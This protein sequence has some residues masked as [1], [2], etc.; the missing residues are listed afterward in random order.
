MES[1]KTPSHLT[2]SDIKRSKSKSLRSQSLI[3]CKGGGLGHMLLLNINKKAYM[4]NL[5][6]LSHLTLSDLER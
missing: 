4:G 1:Q 5:M 3:S 6:T 2:L